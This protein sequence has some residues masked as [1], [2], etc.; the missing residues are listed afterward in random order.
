[1]VLEA[2]EDSQVPRVNP[3]TRKKEPT[4][5][6]NRDILIMTIEEE[7]FLQKVKEEE[8]EVEELPI[9]AINEISW[10]ID[11]LSAQKMKKQDT[12]EDM[13][14]KVRKKT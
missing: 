12:M 9:N 13:Q 3:S 5:L 7:E 11:R 1:M 6:H 4:T 8:V 14:H 2:E 10:D